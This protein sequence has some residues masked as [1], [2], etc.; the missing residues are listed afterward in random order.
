MTALN[1]SQ[2]IAAANAAAML[3]RGQHKAPVAAKALRV[4]AL[5]SGCERLGPVQVSPGCWVMARRDKPGTT[6]WHRAPD[7]LEVRTALAGSTPTRPPVTHPTTAPVRV[8]AERARVGRLFNRE[9]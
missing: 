3:V 9:S 6:I 2:R 1:D 7:A 4:A 5:R 8:S